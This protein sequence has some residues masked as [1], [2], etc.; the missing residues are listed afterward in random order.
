M[1]T[2]ISIKL[3]H[4]SSLQNYVCWILRKAFHFYDIITINYY[5]Y[6]QSFGLMLR[7][8]SSKESLQLKN[9]ARLYNAN[10]N[11]LAKKW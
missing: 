10:G 11:N 5:I 4:L 2:S 1:Q 8:K 7:D 6:V 9:F 3:F